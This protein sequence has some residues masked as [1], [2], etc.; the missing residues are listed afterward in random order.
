[1]T[2]INYRLNGKCGLDVRTTEGVLGHIVSKR[3]GQLHLV[4]TR[5][6]SPAELDGVCAYIE[7]AATPHVRVPGGDGTM[8]VIECSRKIAATL[9]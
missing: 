4:L 6:V 9:P 5:P 3:G 1:M 8:T 2:Y 7:L